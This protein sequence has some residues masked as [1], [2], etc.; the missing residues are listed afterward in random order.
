MSQNGEDI[1]KTPAGVLQ[2]K[3]II[4]QDEKKG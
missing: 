3:Q 1:P 4:S 2:N